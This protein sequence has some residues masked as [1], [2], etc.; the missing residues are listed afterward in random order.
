MEQPKNIL[1]VENSPEIGG[2]NRSLLL[3]L[4]H[5]DRTRFTPLVVVPDNGPMVDELQQRSISYRTI[6]KIWPQKFWLF[7]YFKVVRE[8][9]ELIREQHI[10]LVHVN[11]IAAYLWLGD[12]LKKRPVP[13]VSHVRFPYTETGLAYLAKHTKWPDL[14]V[15]NSYA[16]EKDLGG[17]VDI[18]MPGARK[19]VLHNALD[20]EYFKPRNNITALKGSF[21]ITQEKPVV[22]IIANFTP[23]KDHETFLRMAEKVIRKVPDAQF[24]LAGLDVLFEGKREAELKQL[25]NTLG[26]AQSTH[27]IGFVKEI[28]DLVAS[29]D[30]VVCTSNIETFGRCVMEAM[31]CGKPVVASNVGGIPEIIVSR[32]VGELVEPGDD[33]GFAEAVVRYLADENLYRSTAAYARQHVVRHFSVDSHIKKLNELYYDTLKDAYE[34]TGR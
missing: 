18:Y 34:N 4:D 25:A 28:P 10:D 14:F 32:Q 6:P 33:A 12:A 17:L 24:I 15:Y 19:T 20:T 23:A 29:S 11:D 2:G 16:M 30:V 22:T 26:I 31:S 1:Y 3:I 27:F 7:P 9:A 5:L 13:T 8:Y 21:G